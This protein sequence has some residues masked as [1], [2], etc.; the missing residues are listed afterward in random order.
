MQKIYRAVLSVMEKEKRYGW[1]E[2]AVRPRC[3][4][5]SGFQHNQVVEQR[6]LSRKT[7]PSVDTT[8]PFNHYRVQSLGIASRAAW[9]WKLRWTLKNWQL[10]VSRWPTFFAARQQV[11]IFEGNQVAHICTFHISTFFFFWFMFPW[12]LYSNTN[13]RMQC[14]YEK[15]W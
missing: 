5:T 1:A 4:Q 13:V 10:Q 2:G 15:V 11:F 14:I 12:L 7:P 3:N 9:P 6:L 8:R